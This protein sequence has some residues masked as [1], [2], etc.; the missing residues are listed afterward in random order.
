MKNRKDDWNSASYD[1]NFVVKPPEVNSPMWEER[2]QEA[3]D[4]AYVIT[5][6]T[7]LLIFLAFIMQVVTYI[8]SFVKGKVP[9]NVD[10]VF[11]YLGVLVASIIGYILSWAFIKL[12]CHLIVSTE[13]HYAEQHK[14][15]QNKK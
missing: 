7:Q 11:K 13:I 2:V 3:K 8:V 12:I 6:G 9:L 1:F 14:E 15:K 4:T 5:E 10:N